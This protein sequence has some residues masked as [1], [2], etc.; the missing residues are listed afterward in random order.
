MNSS[1]SAYVLGAEPEPDVDDD[2]VGREGGGKLG[3][4]T[5]LTSPNGAELAPYERT[6]LPPPIAVEGGTVK[7]CPSGLPNED[8]GRREGGRSAANDHLKR[9]LFDASEAPSEILWS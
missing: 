3:P 8:A 4:N 2:D 7:P 1:P 5:L 6:G 9:V